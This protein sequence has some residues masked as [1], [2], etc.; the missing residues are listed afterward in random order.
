MSPLE[1]Y[2]AY[3]TVNWNEFRTIDERFALYMI[4]WED[5]GYHKDLDYVGWVDNQNYKYYPNGEFRRRSAS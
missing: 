2:I 4:D 3:E 5:T 1:R